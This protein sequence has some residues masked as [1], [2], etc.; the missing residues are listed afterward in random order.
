[1]SLLVF[2]QQDTFITTKKHLAVFNL[3]VEVMIRL[4]LSLH[5]YYIGE[6]LY[7]Q[8]DSL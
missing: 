5:F 4:Y 1:M 8:N 3:Y 2:H 7:N 6:D